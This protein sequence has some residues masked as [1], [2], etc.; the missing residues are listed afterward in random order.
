MLLYV[1][2]FLYGPEGL[3]WGLTG[4]IGTRDIEKIT[5]SERPNVSVPLSRATFTATNHILR[6]PQNIINTVFKNIF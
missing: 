1:V 6:R 5:L 3:V 4:S 2:T